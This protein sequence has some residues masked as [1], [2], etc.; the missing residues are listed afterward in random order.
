MNNAYLKD[1]A[2]MRLVFTVDVLVA[3]G[4][5]QHC[6]EEEYLCKQRFSVLINDKVSLSLYLRSEVTLSLFK[7]LASDVKESG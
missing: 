1:F 6:V 2:S 7:H 5:E 4:V 3:D